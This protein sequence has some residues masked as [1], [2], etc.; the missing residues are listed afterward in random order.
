MGSQS[1]APERRPKRSA[2]PALSVGIK[3]IITLVLAAIPLALL[4]VGVFV[5]GYFYLMQPNAELQDHVRFV[6]VIAAGVYLVVLALFSFL[7]GALWMWKP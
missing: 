5:G 4:A 6:L 1:P 7:I 2:W 3:L